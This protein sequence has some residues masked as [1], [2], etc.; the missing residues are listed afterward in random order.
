MSLRVDHEDEDR[1]TLQTTLEGVRDLRGWGFTLT[2][3]ADQFEFLGARV[4]SEN[5]FEKR[6]GHA[7][8]FLVHDEAPGRVVLSSA[9]T[10]GAAPVGDGPIAE[11]VFRPKASTANAIFGLDDGM[12][13]DSY[14]SPTRVL[15]AAHRVYAGGPS[16][17]WMPVPLRGFLRS[18]MSF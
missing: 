5:L 18:L 1:M 17:S 9:I 14:S 6:G 4:P 12:V 15:A 7:P 10:S 8:L 11:M 3:D 16:H 13:F 2:F